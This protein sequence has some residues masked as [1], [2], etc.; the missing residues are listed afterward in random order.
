ESRMRAAGRGLEHGR[1]LERRA[2]CHKPAKNTAQTGVNPASSQT[3]RREATLCHSRFMRKT[4][5][6]A[7]QSRELTPHQN[8]KT[9]ATKPA[10][11]DKLGERWLATSRRLVR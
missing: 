8:A 10:L 4:R 7:F 6:S 9:P 2:Q 11:P 1:T 3:L 5:I